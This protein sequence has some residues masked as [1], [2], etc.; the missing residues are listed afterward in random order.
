MPSLLTCR[1]SSNKSVTVIGA[2]VVGLATALEL[3]ERGA[4]VTLIER[5]PRAWRNAGSWCAGGMLAPWCEGESAPLAVVER[6]A[7]AI[8]WWSRHVPG[9]ARNGTL[10]VAAPRDVGEIDRFAARTR[11]HERVD[12]ARIARARA[13]SR[14]ALPQGLVLRQRRPSR[15]A[16]GAARVARQLGGARRAIQIRRRRRDARQNAASLSIAAASPRAT[17]SPNCAACA[18]R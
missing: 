3:A 2:G 5:S 1:T 10:V 18:A 7:K 17:I 13:R 8:D 9:V 4:Q 14:R 11:E 6:G 16:R 15:S 12:E